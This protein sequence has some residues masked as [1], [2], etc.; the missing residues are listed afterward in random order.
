MDQPLNC[1]RWM[2]KFD[3]FEATSGVGTH[4]CAMVLAEAEIDHARPL[5]YAYLRL[6]SGPPDA[7]PVEVPASPTH[8]SAAVAAE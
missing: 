3:H 8:L 6:P 2:R 7:G 1:M 5:G 4:H